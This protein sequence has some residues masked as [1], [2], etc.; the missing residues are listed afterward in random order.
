MCSAVRVNRRSKSELPGKV[1]NPRI[2]TNL[3]DQACGASR[4]NAV[5][6]LLEQDADPRRPGLPETALDCFRGRARTSRVENDLE[7]LLTN[8]PISSPI[9]HTT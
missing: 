4:P 1:I 6:L 8:H 7:E 9:H 2:H 3:L 5:E